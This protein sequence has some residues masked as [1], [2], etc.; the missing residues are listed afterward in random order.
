MEKKILINHKNLKYY[1]NNVNFLFMLNLC[2][3]NINELIHEKNSI[4]V[5]V[6]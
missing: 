4:Y 6:T 1:I 3:K 5:F 2:L